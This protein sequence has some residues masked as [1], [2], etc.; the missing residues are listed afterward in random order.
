ME[1][2]TTKNDILMLR[3]FPLNWEITQKYAYDYEPN[4]ELYV[5]NVGSLSDMWQCLLH[6]ETMII[7]F[8][9]LHYSNDEVYRFKV[10]TIEE[11]SEM[12]LKF[13]KGMNILDSLDN[14]IYMI[15]KL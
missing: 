10:D 9:S 14:T 4:P 1:R 3:C 2:F 13:A 7:S 8:T 15:K 11:A 6:P 5:I 12:V